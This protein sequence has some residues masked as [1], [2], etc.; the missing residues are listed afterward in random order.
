MRC[1]RPAKRQKHKP[2]ETKARAFP[3]LLLV[4]SLQKCLQRGQFHG[5]NISCDIEICD[6]CGFR[7]GR[8]RYRGETFAMQN[9]S[10]KRH[11]EIFKKLCKISFMNSPQNVEKIAAI[12][13]VR[14]LAGMRKKRRILSWPLA[15]M[16]FPIPIDFL[17]RRPLSGVGVFH[18]QGG[19][20]VRKVPS[21][22]RS[23]PD[24]EFHV[25]FHRGKLQKHCGS[26]SCAKRAVGS[27]CR[28][29]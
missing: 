29:L 28:L 24:C 21:K 18:L 3:P 2:C 14:I 20:G 11:R 22:V 17:G 12:S 4:R 16:A 5:A 6:S 23:L 7:L 26:G 10:A 9:H 27:F 25:E 19:G 8:G 1:E 15:V 13:P